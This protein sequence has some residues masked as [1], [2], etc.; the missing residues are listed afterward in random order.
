[1]LDREGRVQPYPVPLS[2][3]GENGQPT[4]KTPVELLGGQTGVEALPVGLV[5]ATEYQPVAEWRPS[6]LTPGLALLALMDNTVA[7]RRDPAHSMP[8]LKQA[9]TGAIAL[10]SKR[11]EAGEMVE[12]LLNTVAKT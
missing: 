11:G 7:A 3:R 10:K 4:C 5:V 1:M 12:D 2:I 9:V 8:I 6:V